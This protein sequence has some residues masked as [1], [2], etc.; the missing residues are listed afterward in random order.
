MEGES[1]RQIDEGASTLAWRIGFERAPMQR[2][3]TFGGNEPGK[4]ADQRRLAGTVRTDQCDDLAGLQR[5]AGAINNKVAADA[6]GDISR[7]QRWRH[8]GAPSS[9][10]RSEK[11]M[12]RK[13]GTPMS[14]V[15][16]PTR[17]PS[18]AGMAR[19]VISA[20]GSS[21]APA[22]APGRSTRA[23]S[24]PTARRTRCGA[25]RPM[26]PMEPA[27]AT[28]APTPNATPVTTIIRTRPRSTPS[29]AAASS[30]IVSARYA[31]AF[32]ASKI[33]LASKNG[34]AMRR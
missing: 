17:S 31:R 19:T 23:G 5:E 27:I 7:L 21:A 30:P 29:D 25:T 13:N 32:A 9:I 1:V 20:A 24:A 2:D 6:D 12:T 18:A 16:T 8:D 34:A 14:A 22:S 28:A 10:R 15:T 26:N 3:A 4:R 11:I 33:Q